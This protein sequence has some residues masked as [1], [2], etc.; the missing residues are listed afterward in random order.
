MRGKHNKK[1]RAAIFLILV[2]ISIASL[3]GI[4]YQNFIVW[5]KQYV[6]LRLKVRGFLIGVNTDTDAVNFGA[7]P[8]GSAGE[9][10]INITNTDM[11]PHKIMIKA[12]GN[13]SSWIAVSDNGFVLGPQETKEIS[14]FA[15]VPEGTSD[16]YYGGTLEIV[17]ENLGWW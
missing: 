7:V 6:D 3:Y 14:V 2:A 10:K 15:E 17:F 13:I 9:R 5:D 12:H 8:A 4:I 1:I 11:M 16:G